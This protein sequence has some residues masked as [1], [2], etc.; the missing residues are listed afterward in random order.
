MKKYYVY[1]LIDPVNRIPFYIGKGC[2]KR[3]WTHLNGK[4]TCNIK[5]HKYIDSLRNLDIEPEVKFI[6]TN[7]VEKDAYDLE[8]F[9]IKEAKKI[10][11]ITNIV[12]NKRPPSRKGC[13]WSIES[14]N[15]R[16][17]TIKQNYKNG[18]KKPSMSDEQK[19]KLS[20]CNLGKIMTKDSCHKISQTLKNNFLE[21]YKDISYDVL[22]YYYIDLK[23]TIKDLSKELKIPT[24]TIK[25]LLKRN[26]ILKYGRCTTSVDLKKI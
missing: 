8:F 13:K 1:A 7:L 20:V 23:Y 24:H 3:A 14:I 10:F 26:K 9:C 6:K 25:S 12:G 15:K 4:D 21:K 17:Q 22:K 16:S 2:G 18:Y 5:K 19:E 11:P